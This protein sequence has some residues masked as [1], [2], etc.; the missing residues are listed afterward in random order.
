MLK[1]YAKL[2]ERTS[3]PSRRFS[4]AVIRDRRVEGSFVDGSDKQISNTDVDTGKPSDQ[5][6][7]TRCMP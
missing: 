7:G 4:D 6:P 5:W 2:I 1:Q 3:S